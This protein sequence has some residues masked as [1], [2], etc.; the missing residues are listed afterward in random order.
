MRL[1]CF[2]RIAEQE[3]GIREK[4]EIFEGV[5]LILGYVVS[6]LILS[7]IRILKHMN[8]IGKD[9]DG[10]WK[11]DILLFSNNATLVTDSKGE[12]VN[13]CLRLNKKL[14]LLIAKL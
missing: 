8:R 1:K 7:L 3:I 4:S 14:N 6:M 12:T 5:S 9:T 2:I 13:W 11:I 10:N